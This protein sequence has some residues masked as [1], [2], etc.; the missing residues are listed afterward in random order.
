MRP[1]PLHVGQK[2]GRLTVAGLSSL[3]FTRHGRPSRRRAWA[4]RCECGEQIT[5]FA[6][7]LTTGH[8]VSCGCFHSDVSREVSR[9]LF[10]KHNGKRL[11]EYRVWRNMLNRCYWPKGNAF[12][13]YGGRGISV[14]DRWRFGDGKRHAFECFLA[15]MGRRPSPDL[16]IDRIDNDGNYEPGNCRWATRSQ[17]QNNTR[18]NK[19]TQ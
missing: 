7:S 1:V 5:V 11:P 15:D 13:H 12:Q 19:R 17:Q 16:S 2:F 6:N 9:A 3:P 8:T 18:R 10:T 14:C 4:C